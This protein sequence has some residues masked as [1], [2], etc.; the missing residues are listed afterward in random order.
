[1]I[2][3]LNQVCISS[4]SLAQ[5]EYS[6]HSHSL[7]WQPNLDTC[8]LIELIKYEWSLKVRLAIIKRTLANL[9]ERSN[10]T[11]LNQSTLK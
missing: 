4:L 3:P 9:R 11:T 5:Y 2:H 1:M 10:R 6:L 7:R 8:R